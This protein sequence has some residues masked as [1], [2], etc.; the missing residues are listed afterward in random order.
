MAHADDGAPVTPA[1][2]AGAPSPPA[3]RPPASSPPSLPNSTWYR[4]SLGNTLALVGVG[5]I[6][7]GAVFFAE[8]SGAATS[9]T[10]GTDARWAADR[11]TARTESIFG[12]AFIIAGLAVFGG[13]Q[14]RYFTVSNR[15]V[16]DDSTARALSSVGVGLEHSG[17]SFSY[18]ATF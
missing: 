3:A 10:A 17:V 2:P 13:A 7:V 14:W 12:T 8:A 1:P 9:A 15:G 4:D 5:T 6:A 16:D 11:S 18:G